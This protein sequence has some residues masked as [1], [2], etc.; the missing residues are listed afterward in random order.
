MTFYVIR[1]S[2]DFTL[3]R[4]LAYTQ[5]SHNQVELMQEAN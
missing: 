4:K 3:A 5:I 2:Q 1:K